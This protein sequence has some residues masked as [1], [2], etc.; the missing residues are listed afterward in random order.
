MNHPR[1]PRVGPGHP[2]VRRPTMPSPRFRLRVLRS[3]A[4]WLVLVALLSACSR[5][6]P[7]PAIAASPA[8]ADGL[9]LALRIQRDGAAALPEAEFDPQILDIEAVSVL[10]GG[11]SLFASVAITAGGLQEFLAHGRVADAVQFGGAAVP[12]DTHGHDVE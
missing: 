9:A 11:P 8:I 12:V 3:A 6:A 4:P 7:A 1:G 10:G 5:E 2:S